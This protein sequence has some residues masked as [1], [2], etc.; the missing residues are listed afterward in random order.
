MASVEESPQLKETESPKINVVDEMLLAF[1]IDSST[2]IFEV[3][4][5]AKGVWN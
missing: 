3:A 5:H 1:V 4:S 2:I